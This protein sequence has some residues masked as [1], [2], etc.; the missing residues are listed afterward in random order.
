[1]GTHAEKGDRAGRRWASDVAASLPRQKNKQDEEKSNRCEPDF[2]SVS[3]APR[4]DRRGSVAR[5]PGW[6]ASSVYGAG[7][8]VRNQTSSGELNQQ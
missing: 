5:I 1:M 8:P 6:R 3:A 7:G 2:D 4:Y